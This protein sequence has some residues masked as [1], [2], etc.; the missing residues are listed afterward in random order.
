MRHHWAHPAFDKWEVPTTAATRDESQ[1]WLEKFAA[2]YFKSWED[3]MG[4]V[5]TMLDSGHTCMV[6][7]G[8]HNLE[9][10][11]KRD[12]W[13]HVERYLGVAIPSSVTSDDFWKCRC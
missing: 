7:W 3:M 13:T 10:E 1:E 5:T 4:Q 8:D 9:D 12:F 11:T 6:T 2:S